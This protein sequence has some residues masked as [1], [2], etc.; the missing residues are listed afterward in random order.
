MD[1]EVRCSGWYS[2]VNTLDTLILELSSA[3]NGMVII[4][5]VLF[6]SNPR[7][8]KNTNMST[9]K[10]FIQ[11]YPDHK[12]SSWIQDINHNNLLYAAAI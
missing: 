7:L 9:P 4:S 1:P 2:H 3:G 6:H 5:E 10:Q 12:K 11:R 8:S